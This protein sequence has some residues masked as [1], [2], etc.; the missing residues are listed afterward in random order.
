M[1]YSYTMELE[2]DLVENNSSGLQ[3][4]APEFKQ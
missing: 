4:I 1:R 3:T 2:Y